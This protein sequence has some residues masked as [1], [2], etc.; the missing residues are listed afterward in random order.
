MHLS[1]Q[2][3]LAEPYVSSPQ[4]IRIL[5][6][7]WVSTQLYCPNCGH[8][9][10][11]RYAN[12]RPVADFFCTNCAED[13]EL[14]SQKTK[15]GGRVVDGAYRT[16]IERLNQARV[17]N[18]LLLCYE[19]KTLAV[20]SLVLIP[21]H[22]FVPDI[23]QERR[24]LSPL[25][26]R[27]GWVGC[28]ILLQKI[29]HSGR[30]FLVRN[31]ILSPKAQVLAEWQRTLFLREQKD[32]NARGWLVSVMRCIEKINR[33]T[34]SLNEVYA[35]EGEL[36]QSFPGNQHVRQKIRQQLQVLRDRGYLDFVDRGVYRLRGQDKVEPPIGVVK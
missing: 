15:M 20:L 2:E 21:K 14:K 3:G 35:F 23:I 26:R 29:P 34:F 18:F 24:P 1:F 27:A 7:H 17:P 22:F 19:L 16:M 25:A 33:T 4:K 13:Y 10:L 6:E 36:H 8:L 11:D 28:N 9:H 30:I 32:I 12:N 5:S 31:K